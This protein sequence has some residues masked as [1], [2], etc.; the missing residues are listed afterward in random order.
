M[1]FTL[2]SIAVLGV[3][4]ISPVYADSSTAWEKAYGFKPAPY[5]ELLRRGEMHG[6]TTRSPWEKAYGFKPTPY[7]EQ[8]SHGKGLPQNP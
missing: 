6:E 2:G 8:P 4:F 7:V 5:E 1:R 3:L